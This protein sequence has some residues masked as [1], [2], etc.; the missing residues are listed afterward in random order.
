MPSAQQSFVVEVGKEGSS[1][2]IRFYCSTDGEEVDVQ[3]VSLVSSD[4]EGDDDIAV[5]YDGPRWACSADLSLS[6]TSF[7]A[8]RL[9]SIYSRRTSRPI[10]SG[11]CCGSLGGRFVGSHGPFV[12]LIGNSWVIRGTR[13]F[14]NLDTDLQGHLYSYLWS[15]GVDKDF[16]AHLFEATI[17]KEQAEYVKWLKDLKAFV[18]S[19]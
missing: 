10:A 4:V 8:A 19:K 14:E 13:S 15:R 17:H 3:E 1:R 2:I 6:L 11:H 5:P 7:R 16:V 9:L 12:A 18:E